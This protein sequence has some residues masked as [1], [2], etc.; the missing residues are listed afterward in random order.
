V[1]VA[2]QRRLRDVH[3]AAEEL[4][5]ELLWLP[6]GGVDDLEDGAVAVALV[7]HCGKSMRRREPG[8]TAQ[9]HAPR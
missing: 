7:V 8:A 9:A 2:R 6:I 1:Q 5:A 4:L 3:A